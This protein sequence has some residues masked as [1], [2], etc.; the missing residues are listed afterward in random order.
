MLNVSNATDVAYH[1][2][3]HPETIAKLWSLESSGRGVDAMKE[4]NHISSGLSFQ[5]NVSEVGAGSSARREHRVN[6]PPAPIRP[7]S[8]GCYVST[9]DLRDPNLDYQSYKRMM[10]ERD[11]KMGR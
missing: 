3:R 7:V 2:S 9:P 1:L 10:N 8:G 4:L 5:G 6:Q 11:R